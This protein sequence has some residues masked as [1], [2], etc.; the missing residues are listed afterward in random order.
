MKKLRANRRIF[1]SRIIIIGTGT[2]I[3]VHLFSLQ[4]VRRDFYRAEAEQ[5]HVQFQQILPSRGEIFFQD[6]SYARE[7]SDEER[8]IPFATNKKFPQVYV[9]PNEVSASEREAVAKGLAFA[10]EIDEREIMQKLQKEN[11]PY[12]PVKRKLDNEVVQE[13]KELNLIGVHFQDEDW[14]YYPYGDYAG[15]V[16]GF[17][18]FIGY[19][20]VGQYGLEGYYNKNLEGLA[21][22][23]K[24]NRDGLG[25][26]LPSLDINSVSAKDGDSLILTVDANIQWKLEQEMKK[27]AQKFGAASSCGIVMEP[28]TG[29][30]LAMSAT[31]GFDPNNYSKVEDIGYYKNDCVQ[32]AYEPGSVMKAITIAAGIDARKIDANTTY[33]DTGSVNI[34][35]NTINNNLFKK[36]GVATMI[37]VLEHSINTGAIFVQQLL[38]KELFLEYLR[39]FNLEKITGIDLASESGSNLNNL[40]T[41]ID[42]NF[43][44]ASFGQG[45]AVT[46][47]QMASALSALANGGK[48]MKPYIVEK[49]IQSDGT[50]IVAQ[51]EV[52]AEPISAET[53][54]RVSA[55]L[56]SAANSDY[57]RAMSIRNN[58]LVAVKTGTA[59]V[60][61][62]NQRGYTGQVDH[63]FVGYAPAF[64]PKFIIYLK[65]EQPHGV[66]FAVSSLTPVFNE[67]AQYILNYFEV[68]PDK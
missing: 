46:P 24:V 31:P 63:S 60:A 21:S 66:N 68:A 13:L 19:E 28:S 33:E 25:R 14:R 50:E 4:V 59:Q 18:G 10:L 64:N 47:I 55:M 67:V 35:A 65:L 38:G 44:T 30:I 3:A 20:R 34:G 43:A 42:I 62:S 45:I 22:Y 17:V 23:A 15:P 58:Y 52:L 12:E 40:Y 51:Q 41:D 54:S 49:I 16:S 36:Y 57:Y 37:N 29:K 39:N 11:D 61:G 9:V 7:K 5:Q 6:Y 56:V 1:I 53:A 32:T 48:I 26:W 2:A 8:L 27:A